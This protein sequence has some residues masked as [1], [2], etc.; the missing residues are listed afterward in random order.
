MKFLLITLQIIKSNLKENFLKFYDFKA[1]QY[2]EAITKYITRLISYLSELHIV[3]WV[4]QLRII[5]FTDYRAYHLYNP[6]SS[7]YHME[8]IWEGISFLL[9]SLQLFHTLHILT[10]RQMG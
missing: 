9:P 10:H 8:I 5:Y 6:F 7:D 4:I 2:K 3:T 1:E